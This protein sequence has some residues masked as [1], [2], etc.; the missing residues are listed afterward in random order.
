[1]KRRIVLIAWLLLSVLLV[2]MDVHPSGA[3]TGD[4]WG[5]I[6]AVNALR[7]SYGLA[8]YEV[9]GALM[10]A[11]QA[12]SEWQAEIGTWSHS[13]PGG[14]RPHDRAVAFGY[15]GGAQVYVSENVAMGPNLTPQ[16]AVYELWQ[17][18]VH[19]ETMVSTFYRHIGAG[20]AASGNVLYYT[21]VVGT[22]AGEPGG[23]PAAPG[24]GA[25]TPVAGAPVATQLAVQPIQVATPMADGSIIH[26]VQWGQFLINIANAYGIPLNDLLALN[27]LTEDTV[28]YPGDK[29]IIRLPTTPTNPTQTLE[30][31]IVETEEAATPT[32]ISTHTPLPT[33]PTATSTRLDEGTSS[34]LTQ[35]S[36][37]L[38]MLTPGTPAETA[39]APSGNPDFLLLT[40]IV[41]G[42]SGSVLVGLGTA[43]KRSG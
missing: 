30:M 38:P 39:E 7:A 22:I 32:R 43:L 18:S 35:V 21:I 23:A 11:A 3:Q 36:E 33:T 42:V 16:K 12:Q 8:P 26:V 28:I 27:E 31:S 10:A 17:D 29:L 20:V 40:V 19:L 24:G 9:D 13:G 37:A 34:R 6:A 5:L 4:A 2:M 41:L 14:S 25:A 1:M 15:G